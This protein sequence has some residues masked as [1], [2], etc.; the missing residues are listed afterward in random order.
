MAGSGEVFGEFSRE[1][2]L[3]KRSSCNVFEVL[4]VYLSDSTGGER[5]KEDCLKA[6]RKAGPRC[7]SD[8]QNSEDSLG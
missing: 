2:R 4:F 1:Y 8:L 6:G 3:R 5:G 7:S